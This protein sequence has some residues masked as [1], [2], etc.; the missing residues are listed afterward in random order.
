MVAFIETAAGTYH[1]VGFDY[2]MYAATVDGTS[3]SGRSEKNRFQITLTG[4]EDSL[5]Y[6]LTSA[7]WIAITSAVAV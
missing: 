6:N 5:G 4:E 1:M 3:G 7:E 2:G